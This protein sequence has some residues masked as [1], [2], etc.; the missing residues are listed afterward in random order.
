MF[1]SRISFPLT[2]DYHIWIISNF[3]K[4]SRRYSQIRK[5][6]AGV[7]NTGDE[8]LATKS[9]CLHLEVNMK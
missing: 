2:L 7:S 4:Y 3:Y 1:F 5:F 6:I 9:A 8:T